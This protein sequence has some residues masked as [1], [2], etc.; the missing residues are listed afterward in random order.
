AH[1]AELLMGTGHTLD[2]LVAVAEA[3]KQLP[4]F[5]IA[6]KLKVKTAVKHGEVES[7]NV[8]AI[9]PGSDPQLK[10]E[11]VAMSAHIDHL[12]IGKPINGD[13]IFNGAMDDAAGVAAMLDIAAHLKETGVK[14]KRSILFVAVT[15][16]EKG[17]LG[18]QYFAAHPTVPEKSI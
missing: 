18:S 14:T 5:A 7:Q 9:L 16:E 13:A 12:G 15:G 3:G 4:R 11:Y 8:A 17:L 6:G 10:N 1:A 2:E